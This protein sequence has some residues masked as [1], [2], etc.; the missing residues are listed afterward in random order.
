MFAQVLKICTNCSC[1]S[2][3][4]IWAPG[5]HIAPLNILEEYG[6]STSPLVSLA[7]MPFGTAKPSFLWLA[8]IHLACLHPLCP[9][10]PAR[11]LARAP[12]M[13]STPVSSYLFRVP[14]SSCCRSPLNPLIDPSMYYTKPLCKLETSDATT[15]IG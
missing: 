15:L 13:R 6:L 8:P 9:P 14:L 5:A 7:A 12:Q 4:A 3:N 10:S 11:P 1:A 2:T